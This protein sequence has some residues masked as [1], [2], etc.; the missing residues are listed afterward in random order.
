MPC[1][2]FFFILKIIILLYRPDELV[3]HPDEIVYRPDDIKTFFTWHLRAA[4]QIKTKVTI[5]M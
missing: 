3:Y 4:V 2:D 1:E 5:Y